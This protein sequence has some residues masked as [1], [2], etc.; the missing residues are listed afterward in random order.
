MDPQLLDY[1]SRELRHVR[2][3]AS[4]F[5][6]EFPDRA[7]RLGLVGLERG[8]E[9][10]DPYVERLLEGFAFLAARVQLK[11]DAEFPRFSQH[12]LN[13]VYPH[14]LPPTPSMAVVQLQPNLQGGVLADGYVVPRHTSLRSWQDPKKSRQQT[15]CRYRTA[16]DVTLLPL[17]L[18]HAEYKPFVADLAHTRA[19]GLAEARATIRLRLKVT[20]G[21]TW[22]RIR[23]DNL[24]VF[25][26][27]DP[28]TAYRLYELLLARA[29]GILVRP[30]EDNP[31]W[32]HGL[33]A[34]S[35]QP[36]G[37]EDEQGLL[38]FGPQ[39]FQG[40]RLLHEYFAFPQRFLF[41]DLLGLVAP[42]GRHDGNELEIIVL[43]NRADPALEGAVSAA[44]FGLFCTP[45]VNLFEKRADRIHLDEGTHEYHVVPDRARPMDYEVHSVSA[46]VGIGA[47]DVR[48][49]FQPL[50]G[51]DRRTE[52][53]DAF[54]T[55]RREP[56][57]LSSRQHNRGTRTQYVGS[58]SFLALVD[59]QEGP[60][61]S[62]LKQLSVET[63]CTNRD[64]P[65]LMQIG[66][67][68]TDFTLE[69]GAPVDVVR[70]LE[71]PSPPRASHAHNDVTWRLISHLSLNYVSLTDAADGR[72]ATAL[73]ELLRLYSDFSDGSSRGYM[74]AIRSVS[75]APVVR[76]FPGPGP[77]SFGRGLEITLTCDE[78]SIEGHGVFLLGTVLE[79]FFA[80]YVS[81]N[82]FTET[83]LK[84]VQR[85]EIMRW[86]ARLGNRPIL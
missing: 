9:C 62:D 81:I 35:L 19:P 71:G 83:V 25:L 76:R 11:I 17:E 68:T 2:E 20:A 60:F 32:F 80:K 48:Q 22:N 49:P 39:S 15:P 40:Y 29:T 24:S 26:P 23:L 64:L 31:R 41:V 58:E 36:L 43:V 30:A 7:G 61:R 69:S 50:Y 8:S 73:R 18:T 63:L 44:Q 1:Y 4:E 78:A 16:H 21:L 65:L 53:N 3:T 77:V 75:S 79:R 51:F 13:T 14:Y 52:R 37:F 5:A 56:R 47:E 55:V 33:P 59:G 54:Y 28:G 6:R 34:E 67:S 57:R 72:G 86:P 74:E 10:P 84:T 42:A 46:V 27:G 70:C 82:A 12:L 85:G 38:P 66:Q 45:A